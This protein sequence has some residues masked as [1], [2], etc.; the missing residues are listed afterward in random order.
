MLDV[1]NFWAGEGLGAGEESA[2]IALVGK[3]HDGR[4]TCSIETEEK[5]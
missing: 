1:L 5:C 2:F 4:A 3:V